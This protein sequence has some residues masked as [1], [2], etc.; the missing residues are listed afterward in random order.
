MVVGYERKMFMKSA[1]GVNV[2][3]F[4]PLPLIVEQNKLKCFSLEGILKFVEE[5]LCVKPGAQSSGAPLRSLLY[6]KA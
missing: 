6:G 4:F 1:T 5:C 2:D 3:N